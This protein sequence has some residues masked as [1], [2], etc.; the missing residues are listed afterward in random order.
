MEPRVS[1]EKAHPS[2]T[3]R[4]LSWAG[5]EPILPDTFPPAH[6]QEAQSLAH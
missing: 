2:L 3:T 5:L 6:F 1:R 4:P